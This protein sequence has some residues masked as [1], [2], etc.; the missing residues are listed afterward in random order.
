MPPAATVRALLNSR[1]EAD[2]TR[3]ASSQRSLACRRNTERGRRRPIPRPLARSRL[4]LHQ[5]DDRL[6]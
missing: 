5:Q 2:A 1:L 6:A 4:R 3:G